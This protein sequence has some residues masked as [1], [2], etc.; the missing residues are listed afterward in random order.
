[1]VK[2]PLWTIICR[3]CRK[4]LRRSSACISCKVRLPV[5]STRA[6]FQNFSPT[7][8]KFSFLKWVNDLI[9]LSLLHQ[10][11]RSDHSCNPHKWQQIH[12]PAT[13]SALTLHSPS[14]LASNIS[15]LL[16]KQA[17][18]PLQEQLTPPL[19]QVM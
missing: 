15:P 19:P 3:I 10:L 4:Y 12:L 18:L 13:S 1:M 9:T 2:V 8:W 7:R 11:F 16:A 5:P 14:H 17:A 6:N